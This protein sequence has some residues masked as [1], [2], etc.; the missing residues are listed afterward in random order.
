MERFWS[1]KINVPTTGV[2]MALWGSHG[3]SCALMVLAVVAST[4]VLTLFLPNYKEI[5]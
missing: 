4:T 1:K 2:R 5:R 3:P